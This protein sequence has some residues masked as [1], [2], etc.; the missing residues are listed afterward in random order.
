MLILSHYSLLHC[1]LQSSSGPAL[2]LGEREVTPAVQL[3]DCCKTGQQTVLGQK[4]N[5]RHLPVLL[6][7]TTGQQYAYHLRYFFPRPLLRVFKE[8]ITLYCHKALDDLLVWVIWCPAAATNT[9]NRQ[10]KQVGWLGVAEQVPAARGW[11]LCPNLNKVSD[12]SRHSV[13]LP[14]TFCE[15]GCSSPVRSG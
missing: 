15:Q 1:P 12:T 8:C 5:C 9:K 4:S 3:S 7:S 11:F 13:W 2:Q 6:T 14:G 10:D